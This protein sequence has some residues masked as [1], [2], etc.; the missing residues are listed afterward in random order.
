LRKRADSSTD[1]TSFHAV[2]QNEDRASAARIFVLLLGAIPG[3]LILLIG[4]YY[5][6]KKKKASPAA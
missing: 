1:D 3:I 2:Y 4:L 5:S 6:E